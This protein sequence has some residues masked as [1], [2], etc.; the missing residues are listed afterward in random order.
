MPSRLIHD[1]S[2][3]VLV[4]DLE[5]PRSLRERMRGLLGRDGLPEGGGMMIERCSS[6]HMFFMRF[7]LDVIFLSHDLIVRKVVHNLRPWRMAWS[8]GARHVVEMAAG[9]LDNVDICKG[10]QLRIEES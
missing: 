8:P 10:D 7:P 3:T 2:G 1:P 6:I 5:F 4:T 9:A